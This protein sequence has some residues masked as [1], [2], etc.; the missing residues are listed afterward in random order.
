MDWYRHYSD[1]SLLVNTSDVKT[2]EKQMIDFKIS[3]RFTS[4]DFFFLAVHVNALY[5]QIS[6]TIQFVLPWLPYWL[7]EFCCLFKFQ[8]RNEWSKWQILVKCY[9]KKAACQLNVT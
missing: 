6:H 5:L 4:F 7:L 1:S 3:N 8:F 2:G 9:A